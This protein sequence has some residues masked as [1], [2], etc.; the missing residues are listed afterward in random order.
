MMRRR[1]RVSALLPAFALAVV[2]FA[3]P[4]TAAAQWEVTSGPVGIGINAL[5]V[6]TS[7]VYAGSASRG[8]F[9]STD[10]GASWF[11]ANA[12]IENTTVYAL[13]TTSAGLLAGLLTGG[14][15]RSTDNGAT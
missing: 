12:G 1:L 8:V 9:R 7:G 5:Y 2:A 14:V 11:A 6:H 10:G 13:T 3:L 4:A 15:V